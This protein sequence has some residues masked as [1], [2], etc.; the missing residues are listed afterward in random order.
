MCEETLAAQTSAL[1]RPHF[2]RWGF[3]GSPVRVRLKLT[4]VPEMLKHLLSGFQNAIPMEY[5]GLLLGTTQPNHIAIT[6][7]LPFSLAQ[8]GGAG[9]Y[10]V[11]QDED[12]ERFREAIRDCERSVNPVTV[13]GYYRG[14]LREGLCLN[15]EDLALIERFFPQAGSVFLAVRPGAPGCAPL[16]DFFFRDMGVV[17]PDSILPFTFDGDMLEREAMAAQQRSLEEHGLRTEIIPAS[18]LPPAPSMTPSASLPE[19]EPVTAPIPE[20]H[21]R[22]RAPLQTPLM[23]LMV[24]AL[25]GL[26]M[27]WTLTSP[28]RELTPPLTGPAVFEPNTFS[29]K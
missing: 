26:A 23:V 9:G 6:G 19:A 15:G 11:V 24:A 3:P 25:L 13:V 7:F 20:V 14:H 2:Y 21:S 12:R 5:G 18:S 8:S 4:I 16:A 10:F 28:S 27:C 17:F 1:A 22:K 29:S